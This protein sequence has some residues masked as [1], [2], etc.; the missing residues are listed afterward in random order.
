[1]S[2]IRRTRPTDD[3]NPPWAG[4]TFIYPVDSDTLSEQLKMRYP[5]CSTHKQRK[6][7]AAIDFLMKELRDMQSRSSDHPTPT[8][9]SQS[10]P[11]T[12]LTD[13][14]S[15]NEVASTG[16][17][18]HSVSSSNSPC[19]TTSRPAA[20]L[21]DRSKESLEQPHSPTRIAPLTVTKSQQIVFSALDGQMMQPKTKRKMTMQERSAYKETRKR[22]ACAKCRQQKGKVISCSRK[23]GLLVANVP[24][25]TYK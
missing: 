14:H 22:G 2:L 20:V 8:E 21:A 16:S 4:I 3:E 15:A 6:H 11:V 13:Q 7:Q 10:Q 17:R 25:Y 9:F 23:L 19:M 1:M 5:N 24:V 12:P 18:Q